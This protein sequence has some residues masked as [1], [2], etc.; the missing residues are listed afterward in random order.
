MRIQFMRKGTNLPL[1]CENIGYN[2]NQED[3]KR[4]NGYYYYHWLQSERG[5]GIA[6]VDNQTF[7]LNPGDGFLIRPNVPHQ[8]HSASPYETWITGFFVI[9][10]DII[11]D[12]MEFVGI[13]DFLYLPELHPETFSFIQNSY[14]DF[15]KEDLSATLIQSTK[16]YQFIMLLKNENQGSFNSFDDQAIINPITDYISD[17]F[18][19]AITNEDLSKYTGYSIS[20]QNKI[21]REHYGLTPLKYLDDYRLRK[22]KSLMMIHPDW[23]I[24]QIGEAVGYT[25]IS[26]FIHQF[27]LSNGITPH[28]FVK[29]R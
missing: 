11:D 21:F 12:L 6:T 1:F 10:G 17:N 2:W 28:Q 20:H 9:S 3:V 14:N 7:E 8:Y 5:K 19:H 25:D 16:I 15:L 18:D 26:R 22:S 4:P 29:Q 27:K 24:Q 23:L 13:K